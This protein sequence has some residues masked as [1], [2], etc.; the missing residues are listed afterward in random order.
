MW[1]VVIKG[2]KEDS[3]GDGTVLYFDDSTTNTVLVILYYSYTRCYHCRTI[4]QRYRICLYYF[5]QL[6]TN[7]QLSQHFLKS[8][9]QKQHVFYMYSTFTCPKFCLVCSY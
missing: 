4:S 8:L 9:N 5:L 1:E 2:N 7:L 6:H 3:Y